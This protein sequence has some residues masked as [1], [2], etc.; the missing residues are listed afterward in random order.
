[1]HRPIGTHV[2]LQCSDARE[3]KANAKRRRRRRNSLLF[4]VATNDSSIECTSE[5]EGQ[6]SFMGLAVDR[7]PNDDAHG[8]T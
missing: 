1:M 5:C 4:N 3:A 6:S 7:R 2:D 8:G